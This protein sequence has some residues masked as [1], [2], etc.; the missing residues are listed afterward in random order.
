MTTLYVQTVKGWPRGFLNHQQEAGFRP[1][2]LPPPLPPIPG[3]SPV[4]GRDLWLTFEALGKKTIQQPSKAIKNWMIYCK[5]VGTY[6]IHGASGY[7]RWL[8]KIIFETFH[9]TFHQTSNGT[10]PTAPT[11]SKLRSSFQK[12][13]R[14]LSGSFFSWVR[15]LE[16]SRIEA[17]KKDP[18]WIFVRDDWA[19]DSHE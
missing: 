6:S 14:F 8:T 12:I 5:V 2:F 13:L 3:K 16:I 15:S 7:L 18:T 4:A 9:Q 1:P 17:L 11:L 19:K 10:L